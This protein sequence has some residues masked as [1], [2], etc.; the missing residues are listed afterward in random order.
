MIMNPDGQSLKQ[1]YRHFSS[2]LLLLFVA[3]PVSLAAEET[4]RVMPSKVELHGNWDRAQLLVTR[5]DK[6]GQFS[7]SSSDATA[8][9]KY[10]SSDPAI[11]TVDEHGQLVAV[12]NGEMT[13]EV[14]VGNWRGEAQVTVKD[15]SPEAKIQ[16]MKQ[17]RPILS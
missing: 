15:V 6:S 17:V 1:Y 8:E 10:V 13:V 14:Q 5:V 7:A 12:A 16:Y 11:V 2:L 3:G 4:L 9:A